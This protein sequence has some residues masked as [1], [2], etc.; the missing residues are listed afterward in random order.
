MIEEVDLFVGVVY[1]F[2]KIEF[3]VSFVLSIRMIMMTMKTIYLTV[4]RRSIY[5]L[6]ES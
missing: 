1:I 6:A 5:R 4:T 3:A 2:F